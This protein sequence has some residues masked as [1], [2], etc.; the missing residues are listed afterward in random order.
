MTTPIGLYDYK[1]TVVRNK[2]TKTATHTYV[3]AAQRK[4][5]LSTMDDVC[6]IVFSYYMEKANIDG[7]DFNDQRVAKALGYSERKVQRARL[8][9]MK[10]KWFLQSTYKNYKN[11]KVIMTYLGQEAVHTY[12]TDGD[13]IHM[14]IID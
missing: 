4:N 3:T 11:R 5:I 8:K 6:F 13:V 2:H 10:H 7:F 9:L 1:T 14:T 12:V